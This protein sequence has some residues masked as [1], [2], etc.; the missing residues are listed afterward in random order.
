MLFDVRG[1]SVL[2]WIEQLDLRRRK[3]SKHLQYVELQ[4]QAELVSEVPALL[5]LAVH[6][7][8]DPDLGRLDALAGRGQ[9]VQARGM[10]ADELEL[11]PNFLAL[12]EQF[13]YAVAPVRKCARDVELGD[14]FGHAVVAQV[15]ETEAPLAVVGCAVGAGRRGYLG[16]GYHHFVAVLQRDW[17]FGFEPPH[18]DIGILASVRRLREDQP[19][20]LPRRQRRAELPEQPRLVGYEPT[21]GDF[22]VREPQDAEFVDIDFLAGRRDAEQISL[23]RAGEPPQHSHSVAVGDDVLDDV[24]SIGNGV[25][26]A[27]SRIGESLVARVARQVPKARPRPLV[28]G[29]EEFLRWR[30]PVHRFLVAPREGFVA[31]ELRGR[32]LRGGPARESQSGGRAD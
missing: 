1:A 15:L 23:V 14:A 11:H 7:A 30:T 13:V 2:P 22:A 17:R 8:H 25:A 10:G 31:L 29:G 32:S 24:D 12:R 5:P 6:D 3:P 16:A 27:R 21:F 4:Q 28:A 20:V 9:A 19:A 18:H 26:Q